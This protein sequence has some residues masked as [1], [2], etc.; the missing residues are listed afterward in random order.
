MWAIYDKDGGLVYGPVDTQGQ[1]M[2][3]AALL[4]VQY[5]FKGWII[6]EIENEQA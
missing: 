1:C 4:A 2:I 6:K 5:P 3:Q